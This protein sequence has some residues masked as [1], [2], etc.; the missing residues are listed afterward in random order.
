MPNLF[1]QSQL[2]AIADALG[3]TGDGLTGSEN[4]TSPSNMSNARSPEITKR[5]RIYNAFIQT[6]NA[7][8]DRVPILA[9]IRHAMKPAKYA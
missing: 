7:N 8:Q 1:D 5:H 2:Q 3:D 4:R 6:Q 9:F